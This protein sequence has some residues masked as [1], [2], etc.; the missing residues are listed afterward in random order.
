MFKASGH[1]TTSRRRSASSRSCCDFGS[2]EAG[3]LRS[4][5][6]K[7]SVIDKPVINKTT[8]AVSCSRHLPLVVKRLAAAAVGRSEPSHFNSN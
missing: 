4:L 3:L 8:T 5:R 6:K 1:S 2:V 7:K